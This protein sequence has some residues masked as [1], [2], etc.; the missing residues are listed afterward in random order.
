MCSPH[1][2][3]VRCCWAM[4]ANQAR[5]CGWCICI[6][7]NTILVSEQ[8]IPTLDPAQTNNSNSTF[9]SKQ[10][11]IGGAVVAHS[12]LLAQGTRGRQG[13]QPDHRS[14]RR[15][16]IRSSA[17]NQSTA[18]SLDPHPVPQQFPDE[19]VGEHAWLTILHSAQVAVGVCVTAVHATL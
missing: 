2:C 14:N 16:R 5:V 1:A 19:Q 13:E 3:R 10:S 6:S 9:S 12:G 11:D 17:A 8:G 18:R 7:D 4:A 15:R